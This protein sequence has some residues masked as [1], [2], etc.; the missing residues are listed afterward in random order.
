MIWDLFV[1]SLKNLRRRGIKSILTIVGIFIGIAAV[2]ALITLSQGME[3][4][5]YAGFN[6]LGNNKLFITP[7]ISSSMMGMVSSNLGAILDNSDLNEI[8]KVNG[9]EEVSGIMTSSGIASFK[10]IEKRVSIDGISTDNKALSVIKGSYLPDILIG[11]DFRSGSHNIAILGYSVYSNIFKKKIGVG[12]KIKINGNY[13]KVVGVYEKSGNPTL[14]RLV[15]IDQDSAKKL[16]NFDKIGYATIIAQVSPNMDIDEVKD[17]V[18]AVERKHRNVKEKNQDFTVKTSK[19]V[20]E[21]FQNILLVME[22]LLIGIASISLIVGG[23]GIMNNMYTSVLERTKMIGI[24]KAIG[25][26][27]SDVFTLFFFESSLLG[28]SGG[29]IGVAIGLFSSWL[30]QIAAIQM[31]ITLLKLSINWIYIIAILL[32]SSGFGILFGITPAM[33]AAKLNPTEALRYE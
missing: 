14:D 10:N 7:G 26:R 13:F 19:N 29:I 9:I 4:A 15:F 24:L 27:N 6:R 21:S 33:R 23:V 31:N 20:L 1:F 22:V 18:I 28:L 12:R 16:F 25:A 2:T 3:S 5:V 17:R 32:F 30:V 8:K 11:Q